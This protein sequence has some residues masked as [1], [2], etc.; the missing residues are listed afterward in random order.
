MAHKSPYHCLI[1]IDHRQARI[2]G[3]TEHELTEMAIIHGPDSGHGHVHHHSGATGSG[4]DALSAEFL[5]VVTAAVHDCTEILIAGPAEAKYALKSYIAAK[6]PQLD[7]KIAGVET[8]AKT[9]DHDLHL[10][11]SHFFHRAD[12]MRPAA[13]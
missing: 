2:Y 12:R 6:Q 4:H 10:F 11:A 7:R 3:V 9:G 8:F 1:W 13:S 5:K